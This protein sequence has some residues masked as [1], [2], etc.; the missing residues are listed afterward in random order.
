VVLLIAGEE[1]EEQG[2]LGKT[3]APALADLED[4]A[5][6]LLGFLARKE[7]LLVRRPFIGIARRDG[8]ASTPSPMA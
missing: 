2:G 7:M 6:E 5:E 8:D 4:I 3:P 1:I